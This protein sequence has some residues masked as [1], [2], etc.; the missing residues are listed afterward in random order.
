MRV[1]KVDIFKDIKLENFNSIGTFFF[2][3]QIIQ[4]FSYALTWPDSLKIVRIQRGAVPPPLEF[5]KLSH[6][7]NLKLNSEEHKK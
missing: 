3:L 1:K 4:Y 7:S 6:F 5:S 2:E